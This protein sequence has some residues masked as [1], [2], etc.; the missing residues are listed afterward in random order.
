MFF[1]LEIVWLPSLSRLK[2]NPSRVPR[3]YDFSGADFA[4]LSV[5]S[6]PPTRIYFFSACP[7]RR[8]GM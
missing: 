2:L 7:T 3:L 1:L 6:N 4:E 5:H 8:L